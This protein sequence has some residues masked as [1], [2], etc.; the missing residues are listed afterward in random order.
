MNLLLPLAVLLLAFC[1]AVVYAETNAPLLLA[2]A[3]NPDDDDDRPELF[4]PEAGDSDASNFEPEEGDSDP[5]NF[6]PEEGDSN[7]DSFERTTIDTLP[8]FA[9]SSIEASA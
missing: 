2:Q 3:I 8:A 5:D 6:R 7:P 9:R 4:E 1:P